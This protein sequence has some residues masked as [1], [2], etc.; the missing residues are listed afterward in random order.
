VIC[1][2]SLVFFVSFVSEAV[3]FVTLWR[4]GSLLQIDRSDHPSAE[5]RQD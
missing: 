4:V 1:F 2:V 5:R 3:G